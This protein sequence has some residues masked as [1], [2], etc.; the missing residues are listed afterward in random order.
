MT[1]VS[2]RDR[3]VSLRE[4]VRDPQ[5]LNRLASQIALSFMDHYYQNGH[6]EEEFI[7]LLCE[8]ATSFEDPQ[9][10]KAASSALFEVIVEGLCDDFEEF[11]P[12]TYNRVMSEVIHFC[13]RLPEGRELHQALLDFGIVTR[14]DLLTRLR[15]IR[16]NQGFRH[17]FIHRRRSWFSRGSLSGR[18]WPSRA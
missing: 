6:F 16:S 13:R 3:W 18:T 7:Q 12:E 5:E 8:M 14:E 1:P 9:W 15:R 10:S 4:H 17:C 11:Q 2:Y